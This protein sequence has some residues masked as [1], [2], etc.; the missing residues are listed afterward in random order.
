M[1]DS[2][3]S[4]PP[5]G[6]E[7]SDHV[8]SARWQSPSLGQRISY[9]ET[10]RSQGYYQSA[11]SG[12]SK[13]MAH[14]YG[15]DERYGTKTIMRHGINS[16]SQEKGDDVKYED[17]DDQ[18]DLDYEDDQD[19]QDDEV[20]QHTMQYGQ[21]PDEDGEYESDS[22]SGE[23]GERNKPYQ[24]LIR[25]EDH[26]QETKARRL[27]AKPGRA[28]NDGRLSEFPESE[29]EQ[30][31]LVKELFESILDTTNVLDKSSKN[32]KPAQAVRRFSSGFYSDKFIEMKCW[33][34]VVCFPLASL[35]VDPVT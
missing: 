5:A 19:D 15:C 8:N 35:C 2:Y 18:N 12:A 22:E 4:D 26:Y 17:I 16:P 3:S 29:E 9:G 27:R 7:R 23:G 33:E 30:R 11:L 10:S 32:G 1:A 6:Y 13:T 25:N 28:S 20:G 21:L 14:T 31:E 34:I 24:G